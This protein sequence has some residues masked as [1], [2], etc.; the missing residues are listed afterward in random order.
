MSLVAQRRLA[1]DRR[2]SPAGQRSAPHFA[3]PP[4][5][6]R[7]SASS[8]WA[9][10]RR[11]AKRQT[12]RIAWPALFVKAY[13]LLAADIVELRQSYMRW[14]WPHVYQHE[15]S[16][17]M[18]AVNRSTPTGERLFWG[19][20]TAPEKQSLVEIQNQLDEYKHGQIEK[21][22]RRQMR[23]SRFPTPL[24]RLAWWMSLNLSAVRRAR[25]LGTFRPVDRGRL[26][27]RQSV[28]SDL[29]DDQSLPMARISPSGRMLVTIVY[30]HRMIDGAPWPAPWPNWKRFCK[31]RSPKSWPGSSGACRRLEGRLAQPATVIFSPSRHWLPSRTTRE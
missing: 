5:C 1:I 8:I 4:A 7:W 23:L 10:W 26:G 9:S 30:D 25:R 17:G 2:Q 12:P 15:Q 28:S 22:F 11:C 27:G 21:T 16:V 18:V 14:P 6:F 19:R 24:R 3:A 13:G 31:A 29:H 20:F